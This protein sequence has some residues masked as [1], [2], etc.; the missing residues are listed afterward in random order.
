MLAGKPWQHLS[1]REKEGK[2]I[3][4]KRR[5]REGLVLT[6][7]CC[8]CFCKDRH[9]CVFLIKEAMDRKGTEDAGEKA[10]VKVIL[11]E[12]GCLEPGCKSRET[13]LPL[14]QMG[15]Q[16]GSDREVRGGTPRS[17]AGPPGEEAR[18]TQM[19]CR[20]L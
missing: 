2:K 5:S 20:E 11:K 14:K 8:V 15:N 18:R 6:W 19:D 12:S 13:H 7:L 3:P 16:G 1:P 9:S 4:R 10:K 17:D